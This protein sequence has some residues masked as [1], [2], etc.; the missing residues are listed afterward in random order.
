M[1]ESQSNVYSNANNQDSI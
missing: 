1:E